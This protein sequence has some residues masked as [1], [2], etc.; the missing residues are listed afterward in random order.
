MKTLR[1]E[2]TLGRTP[3]WVRI[4]SD[5]ERI[6]EDGDAMADVAMEVARE[7]GRGAKCVG[8]G[9]SYFSADGREADWKWDVDVKL[10]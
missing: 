6:L 7:F 5:D 8:R 3:N 10:P 2:I 4:L 1:Y 9:Y